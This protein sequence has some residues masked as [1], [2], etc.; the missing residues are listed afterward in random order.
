MPGKL[1]VHEPSGAEN[2][3]QA[4]VP[5]AKVDVG[6][7]R[8]RGVSVGPESSVG[9]ASTAGVSVSVGMAL[10]TLLAARLATGLDE[11]LL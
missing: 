8:G 2:G 4:P 9:V 7:G 1:A 6:V 11:E 3:V 10:A 5:S